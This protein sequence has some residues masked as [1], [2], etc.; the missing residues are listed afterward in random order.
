M[1]NTELVKYLNELYIT[2]LSFEWICDIP[3]EIATEY[4]DDS[5]VVMKDLNRD[6]H[7]WYDTAIEVRMINHK[8]IGTRIVT[9]IKG[10]GDSIEDVNHTLKFY[11]MEEVLEPTYK[12][13]QS[14]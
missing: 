9:D 5:L 6:E 13:I 3:S 14:K 8:F 11:E 4:F 12:I 1:N 2:Q 7:R 10:R